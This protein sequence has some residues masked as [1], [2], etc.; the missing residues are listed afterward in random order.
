ML[1]TSLQILPVLI[2]IL[3]GWL[4]R[5]ANFAGE[6]FWNGAEK[7]TYY[8][9]FPALLF[10]SASQIDFAAV[11]ADF[12]A[13][14]M[15]G[16]VL[17]AALAALLARQ[18]A[19]G[20]GVRGAL[21]LGSVRPNV[22][23]PMAV[24]AAALD[25]TGQGLMALA[26]AIGV[27]MV[28][29]FSV[30]MA[31]RWSD[32]EK[33]EIGHPLREVLA[34]PL[35]LAC[36]AGLLVSALEWRVVTPVASVVDVL[37]RPALTLGLLSVGGALVRGIAGYDRL[38]GMVVSSLLRLAVIPAMVAGLALLLGIDG[39]ALAVLVIYAMSPASP[40]AYVF[41]VR[42]RSDATL[43]ASVITLQTLI[44][45]VLLPFVVASLS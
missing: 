2:L 36:L 12:A 28:N 5:R 25:A 17:G 42:V 30:L 9:F 8:L 20:G 19:T 7:A 31:A 23:I 43:L 45:L 33:H 26:V 40:S 35:I 34:N 1:E 3:L 29:F 41:A 38:A 14:L 6:G 27:P 15:I 21:F 13:A 37:S 16:F 18:L 4:L 44:A 39:M 22:Y 11:E 24:A 10:K 32:R